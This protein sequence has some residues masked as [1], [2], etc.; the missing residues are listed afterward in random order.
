M[1]IRSN[2][3]SL[4]TVGVLSNSWLAAAIAGT[5]SLQLAVVY[6]P[7]FNRLFDTL[8]LSGGDLITATL[9]AG[10]ILVVVELEKLLKRRAGRP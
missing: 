7:P 4:L 1:A 9:L 6:L 2:A 3:D 8:P 5:V 10:V